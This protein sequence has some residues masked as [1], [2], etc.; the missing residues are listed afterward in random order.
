MYTGNCSIIIPAHNEETTIKSCCL[1]FADHARV[2]EVI[3]VANACSDMT[4][5]EALSGNAIVVETFHKGKGRAIK[6]GLERAKE[7]VVVFFDGDI[8]NPSAIFTERLLAGLV[9]NE[10]GLVKGTFDRSEQPGPVTDMLVKPV[11][12][13]ANHPAKVISQPLSG[14]VAVK[15]DFARSIYIPDDFGIELTMLLAAYEKKLLVTETLLPKIEHRQRP[16]SHYMIMAVEVAETF[17]R[18]GIIANHKE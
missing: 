1:R 15:R 14:M 7:D 18:F 9:S 12:E 17:R 11:L 4:Y 5:R 6:I 16:W 8:K 13:I 10:V 3:V 2:S